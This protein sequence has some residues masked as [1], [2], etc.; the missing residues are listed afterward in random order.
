MAGMKTGRVALP[1]TVVAA[2]GGPAMVLCL[3]G[4]SPIATVATLRLVDTWRPTS[5]PAVG[6]QVSTNRR[7]ATVAMG[8]APARQSTIAGPPIAATTVAG[9]ATR[10][11]FI[12]AIQPRLP[13][14]ASVC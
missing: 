8:D 10:P 14:S 9:S 4:A 1:A 12:P 7:V 6:R 11:V 5:G 13:L 2:M 3:A